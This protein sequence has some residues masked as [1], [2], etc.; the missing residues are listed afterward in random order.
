M[1]DSL[2]IVD[3]LRLLETVPERIPAGGLAPARLE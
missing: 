1:N 2:E 3:A